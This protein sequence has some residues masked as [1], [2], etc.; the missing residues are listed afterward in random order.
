MPPPKLLL[1]VAFAVAVAD[2][3][4]LLVCRVLAVR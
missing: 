4:V 3:A 1:A 2:S